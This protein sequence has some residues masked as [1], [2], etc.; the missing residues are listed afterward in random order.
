[1]TTI[2]T[3]QDISRALREHPEWREELR[4]ELLTDELLGLPQRFAEYAVATDRR[5][6]AL[7]ESVAEL[8]RHAA[9]TDRRLDNIDRRLDALTE[10]VAE[11][12]RHAAETDRRLESLAE[13]VRELS[14]QMKEV[15]R[16][17]DHIEAQQ[18]IN[19]TQLG[20]FKG[21]FMERAARDDAAIIASDM[22]LRE[23]RTLPRREIIELADIAVRDGIAGGIPRNHLRQFR[24]ADII[25][26][27]T[28]AQGEACYISV[29]ISYTADERDTDRAIRNA[30]FL[31]R[32]TDIPAYAA[33]AGVHNDKSIEDILIHEAP[34]P[35]GYAT[36]EKAFWSELEE[37]PTAS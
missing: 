30:G 16:R 13:S 22:G 18:R 14:E 17:L 6:D 8:A 12:T 21:I 1:M 4:R 9:E 34:Q 20:D 23:R 2:N 31:T 7:T 24:R 29:E 11:L 19:N 33:V 5:L 27:A 3:I 28:D 32:F 15:T 10:S 37:P 36:D 25:M 35:H 26:E